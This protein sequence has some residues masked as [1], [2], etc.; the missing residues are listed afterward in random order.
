MSLSMYES[1]PRCKWE[2]NIKLTLTER[3]GCGMDSNN[4]RKSNDGLLRT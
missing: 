1:R 2:H 3:A 4:S